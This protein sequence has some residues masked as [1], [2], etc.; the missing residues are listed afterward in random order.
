MTRFIC[1]DLDYATQVLD[2]NDIPFDLD[3]GDRI[4]VDDNY[5][6]EAIQAMDENDVDY[7]EI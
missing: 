1:D 6:D 7:E 4:M 5:V 3:S 2:D